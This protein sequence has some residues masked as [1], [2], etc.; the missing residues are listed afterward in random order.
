MLHSFLAKSFRR[1]RRVVA[2][3]LALALAAAVSVL[4]VAATGRPGPDHPL[5]ASSQLQPAAESADPSP[6]TAPPSDPQSDGGVAAED[7]GAAQP[8]SAPSPRPG[9]SG[10]PHEGVP[11]HA[12]GGAAPPPPASGPSISV[13]ILLYHYIRGNPR[14]SDREGFRLSVTPDNFARQMALLHA[15]GVHTVSLADVMNA[16]TGGPPLPPR[17]VVLTFDDGHD[18]FAFRAVPV[19]SQYGFTATN[20][21]VPGFLGRSSYM[22]VD[23]LHDAVAAGMTIGAHTMHHVDLA[24]EPA[25]VATHEITQSRAVLQQLTGQPVDDFAYPYGI[26]NSAVVRMV[27]R[28]GFRDASTTEPG[29]HQYASQPLLLRRNAISGYDSLNSFAL[30]AGLPLPP[31]NWQAANPPASSASPSPSGSGSPSP[32]GSASPRATATPSDRRHN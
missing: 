1:P 4:T 27:A 8:A 6:D 25:A 17:S 29:I 11:G 12:Q 13:P 22:S 23:Q 16:L 24:A 3:L 21:V 26:F 31:R 28:A 20:F 18:D 15:D 10:G 30:K 14:A 5:V 19:L 7:P 9:P 32:S 2:I